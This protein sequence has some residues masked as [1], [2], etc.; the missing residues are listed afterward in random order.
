ML[1]EPKRGLTAIAIA[2]AQASLASLE[3]APLACS[4]PS[5]SRPLSAL[6]E[7]H[8]LAL[9]GYHGGPSR[10]G[11]NDTE[12]SLTADAARH[13][14]PAW[15]SLA[16]STT[17]SSSSSEVLLLISTLLRSTWRTWC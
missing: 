17:P 5:A 11:W 10:L 8:G 4:K 16:R 13:Q 12:P 9:T 2:I 7:A 1:A 6:P 3:L 15:S 14:A